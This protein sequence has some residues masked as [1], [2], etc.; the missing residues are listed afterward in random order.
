MITFERL[1]A[2]LA[3][4]ALLLSLYSSTIGAKVPPLGLFLD[5]N[6][7]KECHTLTGKWVPIRRV[8]DTVM[9]C[10]KPTVDGGLP[11]T[12]SEDCSTVCVIDNSSK[13]PRQSCYGWTV[14]TGECLRL[15]DSPERE[16]CFD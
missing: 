14:V 3:S 1:F 13:N 6:S 15:A 11:C 8:P 12:V 2:S 10:A 16:I 7:V 5:A 9:G 4:I